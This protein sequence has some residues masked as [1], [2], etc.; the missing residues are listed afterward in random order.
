MFA[1]NPKR[2]LAKASDQAMVCD[3]HS[4]PIVDMA[5]R[6]FDVCVRRR[7]RIVALSSRHEGTG[8]I[9]ISGV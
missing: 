5:V 8:A 2:T 4:W 3:V 6:R 9:W 7:S 1:F